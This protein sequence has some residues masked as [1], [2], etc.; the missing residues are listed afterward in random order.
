MFV[1]FVMAAFRI[2]FSLRRSALSGLSR[3][4]QGAAYRNARYFILVDANTFAHCLPRLVAAVPSLQEA[5]FIELPVGEA[6]KELSIA[7]QVWMSLMESGA[8]ADSIIVNLGGGCVCDL[9]GFVAAGFQRGIRYVNIPTT[10]LAMADAAIGGKTAVNLQ[11]IKNQVGFFYPPEAVCIEPGFLEMLP[12]TEW[13][14]GRFELLKCQLLGGSSLSAVPWDASLREVAV[15]ALVGECAR[16]KAAVCHSDP[17][18]RGV[19]RMLNFGHTFGH[20]LESFMM[21]QG[22][23]VPH[24]MAVAWGMWFEL[25]LSVR[26]MGCPE[27]VLHR[28]ERL[29]QGVLTV[30]VITLRD[31]ECILGFMRHDKKNAEGTV[32]CVL[33]KEPGCP[34]ID[35]PLEENEIRDILLKRLPA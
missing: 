23:P 27:S 20:A 7:E 8:D 4:L 12:E 9:G 35:V 16:F 3:M 1:L 24:G 29:V 26:K 19:R 22:T 11:G 13:M 25:L 18:D 2:I 10:L 5:E 28:Y 17:H 14:N 6:A 15:G 32:R 33:L 34:V 21:Q 30:P 31:T